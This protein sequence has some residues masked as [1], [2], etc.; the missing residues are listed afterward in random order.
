[1][2]NKQYTILHEIGDYYHPVELNES[3]NKK[4][5]EQV[6]QSNQSNQSNKDN[7]E[8]NK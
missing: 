6:N 1:M 7:K 2:E 5:N 4:I 8:E 3:D